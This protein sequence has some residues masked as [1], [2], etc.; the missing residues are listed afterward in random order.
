M[1]AAEV[2]NYDLSF[3]SIPVG[4]VGVNEVCAGGHAQRSDRRFLH[5]HGGEDEHW[6]G[7]G[8]TDVPE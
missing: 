3:T 4:N 7:H 8:F 5:T 2:A 1:G 6:A